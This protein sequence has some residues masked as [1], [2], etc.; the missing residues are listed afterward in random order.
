MV[1][2]WFIIGIGAT[3]ILVGLTL[4]MVSRRAPPITWVASVGVTLVLAFVVIRAA[5]FHQ[6]DR[7]I[8]TRVFG[9][10][11]NWILEIGGIAM[12]LITR[13]TRRRMPTPGFVS[14]D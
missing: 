4:L 8:G 1:Q 10:K 9:L 6:F 5:S 11:C 7:F 3:C 12:V 14:S 2:F 13:E